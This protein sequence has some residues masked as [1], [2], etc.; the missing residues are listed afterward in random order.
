MASKNTEKEERDLMPLEEEISLRSS[1][2]AASV[3]PEKEKVLKLG[4]TC[5]AVI[6]YLSQRAS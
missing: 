5:T 2:M 4:A 3:P 1:D 6:V